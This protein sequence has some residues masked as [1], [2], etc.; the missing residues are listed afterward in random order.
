MPQ[1]LSVKATRPGSYIYL[2]DIKAHGL[3]QV[4]ANPNGLVSSQGRHPYSIARAAIK[5][6]KRHRNPDV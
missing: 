2:V 3:V 1:V 4:V 5:A 6:V